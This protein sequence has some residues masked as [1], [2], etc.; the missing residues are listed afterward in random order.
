[1]GNELQLYVV[2]MSLDTVLQYVVLVEL[3][4]SALQHL[5]V[6][7]RWMLAGIG[8]GLLVVGLLIWPFTDSPA[9][10]GLTPLWHIVPRLQST[11]S[12][13]RILFFIALAACSHFLSLGWRDREL[14]VATGLGAYSLM[15]FV[16]RFSMRIWAL[17][18]TRT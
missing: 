9:F 2:D 10:A 4:W 16:D 15:S 13:L 11:I 17:G 7:P 1:V 5:G 12:I 3:T 14:Q 8:A 18:A 6:I